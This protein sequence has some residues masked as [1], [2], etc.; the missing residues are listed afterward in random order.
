MKRRNRCKLIAAIMAGVMTLSLLSGCGAKNEPTEATDPIT[1][2]MWSN[3]LYES[4]APYVQSQLPD[5]NIEFVVGNNDLDFYKFMKEHGELPDIITCRRFALHDAVGLKDQLMDLST[6]QEAGAIYDAYLG[7]FTNTDGT[8]NWLPLCGE[9]DGLIA[10]RA[11]FEEYGIPLPTDYDSLVSA[12]QAFEAVGIRGFVADFAYDYTCMGVLQ[13][14]SIPEINSMEGRMWRSGYEDPEDETAGLDDTVWPGAFVRMEQFIE[15]V[16]IL[17]E[18][19]ELDYDPVIEM[20]T[21]G[22]AAIIRAGGWNVVD[23]Q[24]RNVDAVFLPYFGQNGEQWLLTYPQFQV[25]LNKDLEKDEARQ[26]KAM[27]VLSTMLSEEAQNILAQGG[28]VITYSQ[29]IDLEMSPYLDNLKP[30]IEQNHLYIRIASNDFFSVSQDVVSRMIQGEYDAQ[31]AYEAFNTQLEQPKEDTE[32]I[33]LSLDRS[34][35]NIF[36]KEG[37][38]PAYSAMANSLRGYYGSDVLIAPANSFT[39]SVFQADY[40]EKMVGNM[41]MPNPLESWQRE[42]TGAELKEYVRASV[43]GIEGGFIPFNLGSLPTVSGISIEVQEKDGAYTLT[44]VLRDGDEV[45]DEDSFHVTCLNIADDMAPFLAAE[46]HGFEKDELRVKQQWT[47]FIKDGGTMAEPTPYL[48]V[49]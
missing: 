17:P 10:N 7:N 43:E 38:N 6:T 46:D 14:L 5:V 24:S 25:A 42:M 2:Y 19:V 32:E 41:I 29:T 21:E 9:V 1:V 47:A 16:K 37:G 36:D 23:F 49:K 31:Q 4:Y 12:C 44:R 18:D 26:E 35:S 11:L 27:Q 15:A 30:L 45:G 34:Y 22:K 3:M 48:T 39:G 8:I 28:D 33:V 20:F 13:G 40:T